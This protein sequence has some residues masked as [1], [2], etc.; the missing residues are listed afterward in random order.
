M[1]LNVLARPSLPRLIPSLMMNPRWKYK[2]FSGR[3]SP[4]HG[5]ARLDQGNS[6]RKSVFNK[7]VG[8]HSKKIKAMRSHFS[9]NDIAH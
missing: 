8:A 6:A 3:E 5:M 2:P 4:Q 9:R 7:A 1:V